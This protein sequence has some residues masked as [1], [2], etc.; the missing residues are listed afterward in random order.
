MLS[1]RS[2]RHRLFAPFILGLFVASVLSPPGASAQVDSIIA[3]PNAVLLR[4]IWTQRGGSGAEVGSAVAAL[5]DIDNDGR[6]EF[7]VAEHGARLW[8]IHS[9]DSLGTSHIVWQRRFE[10]PDPLFFGDFLGTDRPLLVYPWARDTAT[11]ARLYYLDFFDA[12][13]G[14]IADTATLKWE[15]RSPGIRLVGTRFHVADLDLDGAD[16]LIVAAPVVVRN[17][18]RS[19][20]GEIWIYRGGPDF[21][22]G[23]PSVV[24]R[25]SELNGGEYALHIGRIDDDDFPD[26]ICVTRVGARIRWGAQD[27]TNLDRPVDREFGVVNR[28]LDLLDTDG[29]RRSD[30][31]WLG[32]FLHLSSS[33]KDPH[34][35]TFDGNDADL[36][37][38]GRGPTTSVYGPLNDS[39][40]IFDMFALNSG[41]TDFADLV[42]SG[43]IGGPDSR[44]DAYYDPAAD[45]LG[46]HPFGPVRMA[47]GDVDG[48]GWRDYITGNDVY[49]GNAGIAVILGGGAYIPRD[50]MPASAI[51]D[52]TIGEHRDAITI[53]PNPADDIVHIA[54]R[55]DLSRTPAHFLVHDLLGRLVARGEADAMRGEVVW[56]CV[57]H[58]AGIYLLSIYDA[59]GLVIHTVPLTK[60]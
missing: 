6:D 36:H 7:G 59:S 21:Q 1:L 57:D 51:R 2:I 44:Y 53:W 19:E 46:G 10:S 9:L 41:T 33:P 23:T 52:I 17:G 31:L 27:L 56:N 54:W 18:S 22:V 55:G 28:F 32:G 11:L 49:G 35:R 20:N 42:F 34:T 30:L 48:N 26:L 25:D 3:N 58:P 16:E 12:D 38:V 45:G 14:R 47:A 29:D 43:R 39:A 24:I 15:S 40:S 4:R 13:S 50:S 37:F 8:T 5:W 60:R